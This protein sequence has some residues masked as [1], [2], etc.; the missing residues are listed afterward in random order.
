MYSDRYSTIDYTKF[1]DKLHRIT[2]LSG[3][4]SNNKRPEQSKIRDAYDNPAT[5]SPKRET[6]SGL[7]M[8]TIVMIHDKPGPPCV[9]IWISVAVEASL[10][11]LLAEWIG[12]ESVL[13][14]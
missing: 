3:I 8:E 7:I 9:T 14:S 12:N 1:Y 4:C 13:E 6:N 11:D 10:S 5:F 2:A